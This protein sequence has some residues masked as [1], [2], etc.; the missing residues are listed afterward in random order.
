MKFN[1]EITLDIAKAVSDVMEGK[2]K[3]EEVK[4][5]HKMYHPET[6]EE[7][8]VQDK[9]GHDKYN[10]K[11]YV[12]EKPKNESPEEPRAKGEKDF[13]DKH[14]VKKSG[15]KEDGTVMKEA[16]LKV[17]AWTGS[18]KKPPKGLEIA[19]SQSSSLGG[20]DVVFKGDEKDL[21]AYAKRSLGAEG[22][23]LRDVQRTVESN[24]ENP[25][26]PAKE[27]S[28]KQKKYQ[29][30]FNKALKKFGVKSPSE[31]DDEKK[32]EFFDYV[33]ANY[34]ADNETDES[35]KEE[36]EQVDEILGFAKKVK[37]KL[38][39]KKPEPKKT[40]NPVDMKKLL[41]SPGQLKARIIELEK[42]L[43]ATSAKFKKAQDDGDEEREDYWGGI[44]VSQAMELDKLKDKYKAAVKA[45]K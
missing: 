11:G 6:G 45:S 41:N 26:G 5:P 13:K 19:K 35:V 44:E 7:V 34:E 10:A 12:H 1:D 9:A 20:N 25:T 22:D 27:E 24:E 42:K 29:A 23:T 40:R 2:A 31:L 17:R 33:D 37:D 38:T 14:V 18:L 8:E 28:E 15:E 4:Y 43:K 30:F 36:V 3:K 39:G 16:M 21:I 32:K